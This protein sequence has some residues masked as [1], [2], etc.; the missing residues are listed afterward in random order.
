M[1][2]RYTFLFYLLSLAIFS[3]TKFIQAGDSLILGKILDQVQDDK[4]SEIV[5]GQ[6]AALSGHLGLYG[7]FIKNAI[8]AYFNRINE[9]GGVK[10]KKLKLVS[11]EDEGDP[12]LTKRNITH[13]L[14]DQ[15]IDMFLGCT[16]TRSIMSVLPLI[17]EQKI[18]MLFPWGGNDTLRNPKLENIINGLGYLTPQIEKI[19]EYVVDKKRVKKIAI[20]HADDDFST[21]AAQTLTEHL[22]QKYNIT[23]VGKTCYNRL[24]V[25]ILQHADSL[26]LS[27]PKVVICI[28]TSMPTVKL[29]SYFFEKGHYGTEFIGIDSTLFVPSIL[30]NKGA[31]FC[32][33]SCVPDPVNSNLK[34]AQN[35]R[36]DIQKYFPKDIFNIL[37][38]A[39]YISAGIT[40]SAIKNIEG[41]IT[42]E[43]VVKQIE[44]MKNFDIDGLAI[45]FDKSNRHAF[46]KD[47]SIIKTY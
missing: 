3:L 2:K 37:S 8:N 34:I 16:G 38:F 40:V 7:D 23:P 14:N 30:K 22:K 4:K 44:K 29:I 18:A 32:Y 9:A 26:L 12:E 35:Y 28:S 24:T 13:M 47:I 17:H 33:A 15:K 31:H 46:G 39:Y 45:S 1:N 42:K 5:F 41:E 36:E 25:D 10:G 20:F 43:A 19:A 21:Q 11:M 27:D 6:S